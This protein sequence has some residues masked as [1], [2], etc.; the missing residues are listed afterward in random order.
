M[1]LAA[2]LLTFQPLRNSNFKRHYTQH[3]ALLSPS[4]WR[5]YTEGKDGSLRFLRPNIIKQKA[6]YLDKPITLPIQQEKQDKI[7][8]RNCS[9]YPC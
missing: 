7:K 1:H 3:I 4:V 6:Q 2:F 9:H 8:P 5:Q